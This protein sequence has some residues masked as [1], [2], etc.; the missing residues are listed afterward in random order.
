VD[1]FLEQGKKFAEFGNEPNKSGYD[2]KYDY[3]GVGDLT[4]Q[5]DQKLYKSV[6]KK[7]IKLLWDEKGQDMEKFIGRWR[8][9]PRKQDVD[10][11]KAFD[12]AI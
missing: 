5:K 2:T 11:Y 12:K 9:V 10:Y 8:G 3:G 4:S 1:R 7:L 6:A